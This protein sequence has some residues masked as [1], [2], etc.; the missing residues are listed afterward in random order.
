M[1]VKVIGHVLACCVTSLAALAASASID[2]SRM[3]FDVF[4]DDRII[5]QH[6]FEF[7]REGDAL[8][9]QSD[10][11]MSVKLL[12]VEVF[13]YE[14]SASERWR[15]GC[16]EALSS[17]TLQNG[18]K[19]KVHAEVVSEQL[20]VERQSAEAGA[21]SAQVANKRDE[22]DLNESAGCLAGY[23]YWDKARLDRSTLLNAQ[24][25]ELDDVDFR[26]EGVVQ[27]DWLDSRA[28]QNI[29]RFALMS[30]GARIELWYDRSGQWLGLRTQRGK[31]WLEYRLDT[32]EPVADQDRTSQFDA[33]VLPGSMQVV[34]AN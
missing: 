32:V 10:V 27:L 12:F 23:A 6:V 11:D 5:G 24:L 26:A 7:E 15:D 13:N 22:V 25:G 28:Q 1:I 34:R 30:N 33:L 20:V 3:T 19:T 16:L 8:L 29:N 18:E 21:S 2:A 14:H 4:L 31:R 17:T 9:V